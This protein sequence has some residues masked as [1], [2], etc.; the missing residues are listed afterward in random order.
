MY[1]T[2]NDLKTFVDSED[3]EI[4]ARADENPE[5]VNECIK[6]AESRI[7]DTLDAVYNILE[8]MEKTGDERKKTLVSICSHLALWGLYQAISPRNIPETRL[9]NYEAAIKDL[10]DIRKGKLLKS[11]PAYMDSTA[12]TAAQ[13]GVNENLNLLY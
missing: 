9:Y 5:A 12:T 11:L 10:E 4:L 1:L 13:F 7:I 3:Y 6:G 2:I 8:E